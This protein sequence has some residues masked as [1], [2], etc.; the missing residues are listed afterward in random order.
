MPVIEKRNKC[1][2]CLT[3]ANCSGEYQNL[4]RFG[5]AKEIQSEILNI[6]DRRPDMLPEL[7]KFLKRRLSDFDRAEMILADLILKSWQAYVNEI[8]RAKQAFENAKPAIKG[9]IAASVKRLI[10]EMEIKRS[11][12]HRMKMF[13][14]QSVE[15][16]EGEDPFK[17]KQLLH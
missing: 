16:E 9:Q 13:D 8:S 17:N 2:Y 14:G 12:D 6:V 15:D 4:V 3:K 7:I 1:K 5:T 11:V 10:P